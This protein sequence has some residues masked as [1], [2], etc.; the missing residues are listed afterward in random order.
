MKKNLP[1]FCTGL[2]VGLLAAAALTCARPKSGAWERWGITRPAPDAAEPRLVAACSLLYA[3]SY[4]SA[5]QAYTD[6]VRD[7]PGSAEA[8]LGLSL[9]DRCIGQRESAYVEAK[10]ALAL[11]PQGTGV[12]CNYADLLQPARGAYSSDTMS[13][14]ARFEASVAAAGKAARTGHRYAV[15]AHFTLWVDYIWAGRLADARRET[16]TLAANSY[17]PPALLEFGRNLLTAIEPNALLLTDCGD[18]TGPLFSVQ[19]GEGFR[20]DVTVVNIALLNS[21]RATA[22]MRDSLRLPVSFSD[23]ELNELRA[24]RDSATGRAAR[25][26][27]RLVSDVIANAR[28]QNRPVYFATI[29]SPEAM[30][31]WK[32]YSVKEGLVRRVVAT[33]AADSSD[34]PRM[35]ENTERRYRLTAA[36]QRIEWKAN[37]SP[38]TRNIPWLVL[39]Y[40]AIYMDMANYFKGQG[41]MARVDETCRRAYE[42]VKHTDGAQWTSRVVSIW[43]NLNPSS[44]EARKLSNKPD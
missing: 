34:V 2:A 28:K 27:D 6:L 7:Y 16:R 9:A 37:M 36:G 3:T 24:V 5:R 35:I 13:D 18:C 8:L 40:A 22:M 23:P 31:D 38:L 12:L 1:S 10:R 17:F 32:D 44:A 25:P 43:L 19:D 15:Y 20:P 42:L 11:D 26:C 21:P 41:D 39:N 33:R 4:D 29:T 30:G 14:S